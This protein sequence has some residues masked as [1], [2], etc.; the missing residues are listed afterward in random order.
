MDLEDASSSAGFVAHQGHM[1]ATTTSNTMAM[2]DP[3]ID[4]DS[5]QPRVISLD[6][7]KKKTAPLLTKRVIWILVLSLVVIGAIVGVAVGIMSSN[8]Q[9]TNKTASTNEPHDYELRYS[10]FRSTLSSASD[11]TGFVNIDSPQS[12]ALEW[13]VYKDRIIIMDK[14]DSKGLDETKLVQRYAVI[15]LL[16]ALSGSTWETETA[17][18]D[19]TPLHALDECTFDGIVCD[20]QGRLIRLEWV[21]KNLAGSL[22]DEISLLTSLGSLDL[23]NNFVDGPIPERLYDLTNLSKSRRE[24]GT[25]WWCHW[26][27]SHT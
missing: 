10:A 14:D 4:N 6:D 26:P 12:Q 3:V 8:N 5:N 9:S 23:S 15:V 16:Y 18:D 20:D 21:N 19:N 7:N 2:A 27:G 17:L 25:V 13:L 24:S 11:S 1:M 22:P